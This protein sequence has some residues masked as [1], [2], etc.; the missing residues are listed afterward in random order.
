MCVR[1]LRRVGEKAR[2]KKFLGMSENEK[3]THT[4][5]H[6]HTRRERERENGI[7][8]SRIYV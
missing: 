8:R 2:V 4:H 7:L 3:Y 1:V 6:T 5:T